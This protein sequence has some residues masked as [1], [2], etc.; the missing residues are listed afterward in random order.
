M[1]VL[2]HTFG[3]FLLFLFWAGKLCGFYYINCQIYI[4]IYI[5]QHLYCSLFFLFLFFKSRQFNEQKIII[6]SV[7][8]RHKFK[9]QI[10]SYPSKQSAINMTPLPV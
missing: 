6:L 9:L 10:A 8:D 4:Y 2:Y 5:C 7:S 3:L 1:I